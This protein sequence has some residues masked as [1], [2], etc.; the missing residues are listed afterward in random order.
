M[1]LLSTTQTSFVNQHFTDLTYSSKKLMDLEFENCTFEKCIF[2]EC[3][4][5]NCRF[6]D[7]VFTECSISANIPLNSK[8]NAVCFKYSKVMGSDW[9]KA[10]SMHSL[11]FENCDISYS[12][13]SFLKLHNLKLLECVAKE[14]SFNEADLTGGDFQKT[15]FSQSIFSKTNLTGS[16]FRKAINYA[17]DFHF[18]TLKNARFSLPEAASLLNSLDIK[19]E[20]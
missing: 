17:I 12:N 3:I 2:I 5:N 14:T 9:T 6:V 19:L 11:I 15:D 1:D 4:F 20:Y 18:N 10:K 13:F 16:D 7:C 8:F